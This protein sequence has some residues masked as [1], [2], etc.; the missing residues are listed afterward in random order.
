M[1]LVFEISIFY[2][3]SIYLPSLFLLFPSSFSHLSD[4]FCI[5]L[6]LSTLLSYT[7]FFFPHLYSI[8]FIFLHYYFFSNMF[9]FYFMY[10]FYVHLSSFLQLIL[11][12][13][14]PLF[15]SL[16]LLI[17]FFLYGIDLAY[18]SVLVFSRPFWLI[19]THVPSPCYPPLMRR[20][21]RYFFSFQ[22]W[23]K[24]QIILYFTYWI[25]SIKTNFAYL[26]MNIFIFQKMYKKSKTS[27]IDFKFFLV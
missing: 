25:F 9:I 24:W 20:Y 10:I 23:F 26:L 8:P 15:S 11:L 22:V 19:F 5:F 7:F 27:T 17:S 3:S 13:L 16:F 2:C 14:W 21:W 1:A 4:L 18:F 6:F 12:F